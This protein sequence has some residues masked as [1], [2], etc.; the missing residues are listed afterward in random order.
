[1]ETSLQRLEELQPCIQVKWVKKKL[2]VCGKTKNKKLL[3]DQL[4]SIW[5]IITTCKHNHLPSCCCSGVISLIR[6][7]I[8]D[9]DE[10]LDY[11][12][13]LVASATSIQWLVKLITDIL[14]FKY[15]TN[16]VKCKSCGYAMFKESYNLGTKPHPYITLL[17]FQSNAIASIILEIRS[18][19]MVHFS[20]GLGKCQDEKLTMSVPSVIEF[21]K[22]F[23]VF[24]F[25]LDTQMKNCGNV[26]VL[27]LTN[28]LLEWCSL[29]DISTCCNGKQKG[30]VSFLISAIQFAASYDNSFAMLVQIGNA[31]R[32]Q[33]SNSEA[34]DVGLVSLIC[35]HLHLAWETL[36]ENHSSN[37]HLCV[38]L[39]CQLIQYAQLS[40]CALLNLVVNIPSLLVNAPLNATQSILSLISSL[41]ESS[42]YEALP[43]FHKL[44]C[45]FMLK[46][47]LLWLLFNKQILE[48]ENIDAS[49]LLVILNDKLQ[50]IGECGDVK[51]SFH[52]IHQNILLTHSCQIGTGGLVFSVISE[53]MNNE[54]TITF[55]TSICGSLSEIKSVVS[56]YSLYLSSI[57]LMSTSTAVSVDDLIYCKVLDV[58]TN[59]VSCLPAIALDILPTVLHCIKVENNTVH[60]NRCFDLLSAMAT[61]TFCIA[62]V[63][64]ILQD[65]QNDLLPIAIRSLIKICK[66]QPRCLPYL[67]KAMLVSDTS[68]SFE[69]KFAIIFAIRDVCK[70]NTVNCTNDMLKL[71]TSF[72]TP[73]LEEDLAVILLDSLYYMCMH[74]NIGIAVL[75]SSLQNWLILFKYKSVTLAVLRLFSL[76]PSVEK[77]TAR[78][79]SFQDYALTW[80]WSKT[81]SSDS[82]LVRDA[83][84]CLSHFKFADMKL[85]HIPRYLIHEAD[86]CNDEVSETSWLDGP[87]QYELMMDLILNSASLSSTHKQFCLSSL[88]CEEIDAFPRDINHRAN[89]LKKKNV[90]TP[91]S[92]IPSFLSKLQNKNKD[93]ALSSSISTSL[94]NCYELPRLDY[95][96]AKM[97][98]VQKHKKDLFRLL[99]Y[100]LTQVTLDNRDWNNMLWLCMSW[101]VFMLRFYTAIQK[102]RS[103]ELNI[104]LHEENC[105]ER[106]I[107]DKLLCCGYWSRNEITD[108]LQKKSV[109][110]PSMQANSVLCLTGLMC[111]VNSLQQK[112]KPSSA[113]GYLSDEHWLVI[114]ADTIIDILED[115]CELRPHCGV[116][117]TG[118]HVKSQL[119]KLCSLLSLINVTDALLV[120][121]P[122]KIEKLLDLLKSQLETP[123]RSV[124]T[125][126]NVTMGNVIGLIYADKLHERN[127]VISSKLQK[128]V[129]I[130]E[131]QME[132]LFA[133]EDDS[134]IDE[135]VS[136]GA[137]IGLAFVVLRAPTVYPNLMQFYN[138]LKKQLPSSISV[139]ITQ[140]M[141]LLLAWITVKS[142]SK[143]SDSQSE[144]HDVSALLCTASKTYPTNQRIASALSLLQCYINF[145]DGEPKEL[146]MYDQLFKTGVSV[147]TNEHLPLKQRITDISSLAALVGSETLSLYDIADGSNASVPDTMLSNVVKI[148]QKL[149]R[150]NKDLAVSNC[151]ILLLGRL[152]LSCKQRTPAQRE[153]NLYTYLPKPSILCPLIHGLKQSIDNSNKSSDL[154]Y[155]TTVIGAIHN[156][157]LCGKVL[158][159]I[160]LTGILKLGIYGKIEA[161]QLLCLDVCIHQHQSV[162]AQNLLSALVDSGYYATCE[163]SVKQLFLKNL[164]ILVQ[165]VPVASLKT[166]FA[167]PSFLEEAL[168][169]DQFLKGIQ[170]CLNQGKLQPEIVSLILGVLGK[171]YDNLPIEMN[172]FASIENWKILAICLL[173]ISDQQSFDFKSK[174]QNIIKS[175]FVT[176]H[177]LSLYL[178]PLTSIT[179]MIV[180]IA[181]CPNDAQI[182]ALALLQ[183][184]F[185]DMISNAP[186][187]G[188]AQKGMSTWM[189][190][191]M[192]MISERFKNEQG[193]TNEFLLK[194]FSCTVIAQC[195][196]PFNVL[197]AN[198][199]EKENK[200]TQPTNLHDVFE[201]NRM[202]LWLNC[203]PMMIKLLPSMLSSKDSSNDFKK[204]MITWLGT[205]C[206]KLSNTKLKSYIYEALS[207]LRRNPKF[208]NLN[209]WRDIVPTLLL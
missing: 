33:Y 84:L 182:L 184:S 108:L 28:L 85:K 142:I 113:S 98:V 185:Q 165:Y 207:D 189:K 22:P 72:L 105:D 43:S 21:L 179:N 171:I 7:G 200:G 89:T 148:F 104:Q 175:L 152:Y 45:I 5:T 136:L 55:N 101:R 73:E 92:N 139:T 163:N 93:P 161:L 52:V 155:I 17:T 199:L 44:I 62:P 3:F 40:C 131:L 19:L 2:E 121:E 138:Q 30:I 188:V 196:T 181:T 78:F 32:L 133:D 197:Y 25:C 205:V 117:F 1:M 120:I 172:D 134:G 170:M 14:L 18:L 109:G 153:P 124:G 10:V 96:E 31:M 143:H 107:Q 41:V 60:K 123:V 64:H 75:W 183:V 49:K 99:E 8:L 53:S 54:N 86:Q 74:G 69:V 27:D 56:S 114:I 173:K 209:V 147:S 169:R 158:P 95:T 97:S 59:F 191:I 35:S 141:A 167:Y 77:P 168:L 63:L 6:Q 186:N 61:N 91:V 127:K 46:V 36:Q 204:H 110:T 112:E 203:I 12:L 150:N 47:G 208:S 180:H 166:M 83:F 145:A 162:S 126:G 37:I 137:L 190:E 151:L 51:E 159:P 118:E 149:I 119:G 76:I 198:N 34:I 193:G 206:L 88:I 192:G 15:S 128:C 90:S 156:A 187:V 129:K 4:S 9:P 201:A 29:N 115:R 11:I 24:H 102:A 140:N 111:A 164:N 176:V 42:S 38:T 125:L 13:T 39:L 106:T 79:Q 100:M 68:L 66:F 130:L 194:V 146:S 132:K 154:Q 67:L 116:S 177:Q 48:F 160:D 80:I 202:L 26:H 135:D 58:L 23:L 174:N 16:S 20:N 157:Q 144:I 57:L 81:Q 178:T 103:V 87:I 70:N 82:E 195:G 94:L 122:R 71:I 50:C 65:L